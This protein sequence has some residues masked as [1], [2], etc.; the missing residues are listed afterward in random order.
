MSWDQTAVLISVYGTR[1]F[2][3]TRR[4]KIIINN[5]GSNSWEDDPMGNH[6]FV[7]QKMDPEVLSVFIEDRMMHLPI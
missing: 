1:G 2:F 5:D 4:G 7:V 3:D 6:V